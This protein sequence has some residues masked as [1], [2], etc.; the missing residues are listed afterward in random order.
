MANKSWILAGQNVA[1]KY[2]DEIT[3]GY[4]VAIAIQQSPAGVTHTG[5]RRC[6][7]GQH[8][9]ESQRQ[10]LYR[11]KSHSLGDRIVGRVLDGTRKPQSS[12]VRDQDERV[13]AQILCA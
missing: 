10:Q 5:R 9:V 4:P 2:S 12:A 1:A 13:V 6:V 7:N 11:V 3:P 8:V